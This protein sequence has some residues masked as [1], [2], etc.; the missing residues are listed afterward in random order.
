LKALTAA[1]QRRVT[2]MG[3]LGLSSAMSCCFND[4][5][6]RSACLGRF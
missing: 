5:N 4:W 2:L 6:A 1:D 3:L